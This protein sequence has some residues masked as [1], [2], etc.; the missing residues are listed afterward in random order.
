MG[1]P[2]PLTV[3]LAACLATPPSLH[4]ANGGA[5]ALRDIR[6]AVTIDTL[7]P[8]V[9][10][11]GVLLLASGM[12]LLGRHLRRRSARQT[13]SVGGPAKADPL[14][15]LADDWRRGACPATELALRLDAL[16]RDT[17]ANRAGIPARHLT[18]AELRRRMTVGGMC[19][20][21][22]LDVLLSLG[23]RVKFAG[24]QPGAAEIDAALRAAADLFV[25]LPA[26]GGP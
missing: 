9:L 20:A 8:F 21:R 13:G 24:H 12:I 26:Q 19:D 15:G 14:A 22:S 10:T 16:L 5:G 23:D 17:L 25:S 4:A 3:L 7:P 6:A 1:R 18:S 2:A 11:G